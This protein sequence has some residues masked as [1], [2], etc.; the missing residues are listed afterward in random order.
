MVRFSN[1]EPGSYAITVI[2]KAGVI[3][4]FRISH[5]AGGKY[6]F[7]SAEYDS[8]EAIIKAHKK[9]LY[10]QVNFQFRFHILIIFSR[11]PYMAQNTKR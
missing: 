6:T 2:S 8:L 4:H 1:K 11:I 7:G 9:D 3:K 10:L 5:R